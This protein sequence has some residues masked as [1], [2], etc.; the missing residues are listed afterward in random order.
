MNK[1]KARAS[2]LN[3]IGARVRTL[4]QQQ[5]LA[6]REFAARADLSPRFI[7][8]L[9]TGEGNISIAR[10]DDVAEA[11]GCALPE[12]LPPRERD[13]SLRAQ[14]WRLLA[15]CSGSTWLGPAS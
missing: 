2:L 4:R 9:E 11:L 12:L 5:N 8:Q 13:H 3:G 10:L 1:T 14:A 15:E 6:V 7:N